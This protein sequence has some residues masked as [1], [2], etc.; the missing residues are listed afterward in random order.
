M[1]DKKK[2]FLVEDDDRL[3]QL[4]NQLLVA[5]GYEVETC[6]NGLDALTKMQEGG[7]DL[8][9]LDIMLPGKDGLEILEDIQKKKPKNPIRSII[10][11]TNLAKNETIA[12]ALKNGVDGYIIKS[13]YSPEE[14]LAEVKKTLEGKPIS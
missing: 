8:V 11:L 14:F 7:F 12:R 6:N 3:L 5:D 10:L 4:Y 1:S 13:R 2:I 9:L